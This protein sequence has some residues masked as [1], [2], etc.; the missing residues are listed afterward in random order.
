MKRG[1]IRGL[2]ERFAILRLGIQNSDF[3]EGFYLFRHRRYSEAVQAYERALEVTKTSAILYHFLGLAYFEAGQVTQAVAAVDRAIGIDPE[4]RD[5]QLRF[6]VLSLPKDPARAVVAA[7]E[8]TRLRPDS[9][10]A[11]S[12]LANAFSAVALSHYRE[13]PGLASSGRTDEA[14]MEAQKARAALQQS[15]ETYL[16]SRT[17]APGREQ[18]G[19]ENALQ[20]EQSLAP[21]RV[22]ARIRDLAEGQSH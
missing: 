14:L 10:E 17:L 21:G 12:V 3:A 18:L 16:R 8:W 5:A 4:L 6:Q 13:V 9:A 7:A 20:L 11:H 22:E 1:L 15:L 2:R 19:L